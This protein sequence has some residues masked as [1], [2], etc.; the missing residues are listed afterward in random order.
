MRII[1]AGA[2]DVGFHLAKLLSYEKHDIV[3]IDLDDDKL[4]HISNKLDV[5]TIK[6]NST[7]YECLEDADVAKA[8]LF[9]SV[10]SFEDTNI[11]SAIFAKHLGAKKTIAR[12]KNHNHLQKREKKHLNELGIDEIISTEMLASK[13]IGRLLSSVSL[14]D[15]FHFEDGKLTLLGILVDEKCELINKTLK[16][17]AYLNPD[18]DFITAAILR[19]N[20]TIIPHGDTVFLQDDHAYFIAT[21]PGVSKVKALRKEAIVKIKNVMILGGSEIGYT[22]ARNLCKNYNI[23]IIEQN[24]DRSFELA[25]ILPDAMVVLGDGRNKELLETEGLK[26]M[27][28]FIAVTGNSETN[29]ISS[30]MAKEAGVNR[31]IALV[32]NVD[33]VHLSQNIGI[34]TMINR[35]LIAADF[36]FRYVRR[37]DIISIASIHGVDA[38]VLEFIVSE[39]SK[40]T[41][42]YLKQLKF[43]KQALIGGVVRKEKSLIPNG[44]FRIRKDDRVVVLC[45]KHMV[46]EVEEFFR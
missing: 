16:E 35:K 36:I 4:R 23:K 8:D 20:E 25:D 1:L 12:V 43:P 10:T 30:L 46:H 3:V 9:I 38:E 27:D 7:S 21:P 29:I 39:K 17:T 22:T 13:E 37:G 40:I 45:A 42:K 15:V 33:Y 34:D 19:G 6:G 2:G 11:T 24:K 32:E 44:D 41:T 31:T 5:A 28:A 18:F 14:T 26:H